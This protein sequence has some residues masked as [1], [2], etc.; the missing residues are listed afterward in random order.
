MNMGSRT[1]PWGSVRVEA[2]ALVV[3]SIRQLGFQM[4][5][6]LMIS[7][8]LFFNADIFPIREEIID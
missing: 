2:R 4:V 5:S 1:G 8:H 7:P 6:D 3:F